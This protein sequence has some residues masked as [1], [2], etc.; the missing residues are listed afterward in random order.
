MAGE[1]ADSSIVVRMV[2]KDKFR[3]VTRGPVRRCESYSPR[4]V[5]DSLEGSQENVFWEEALTKEIQHD[6]GL[7]AEIIVVL[8][9][10]A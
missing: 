5:L 1:D 10:T 8:A 6:V 9:E 4:D 3:T 7:V 2:G